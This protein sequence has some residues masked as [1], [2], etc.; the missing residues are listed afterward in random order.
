[1]AAGRDHRR[2][3]RNLAQYLYPSAPRKEPAV[4]SEADALYEMVNIY[5]ADSG[6][7]YDGLG[8]AAG[9]ALGGSD[10]LRGLHG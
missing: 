2:D 10:F 5:P 8:R 9:G 1:L 6:L 4:M 3:V 7:P